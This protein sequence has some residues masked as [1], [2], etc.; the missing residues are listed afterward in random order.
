MTWPIFQS[1]RLLANL[2]VSERLEPSTCR[3][4]VLPFRQFMLQHEFVYFESLLNFP[5]VS[6]HPNAPSDVCTAKSR[7]GSCPFLEYT[8][9]D[10]TLSFSGSWNGTPSNVNI[11]KKMF[12]PVSNERPRDDPWRPRAPPGGPI[13]QFPR[14]DWPCAGDIAQNVNSIEMSNVRNN[15]YYELILRQTKLDVTRSPMT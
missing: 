6:F 4:Q 3:M 9:I 2:Q 5:C 15:E 10:H 12:R 14:T 1:T 13:G 8:E 11:T 7:V